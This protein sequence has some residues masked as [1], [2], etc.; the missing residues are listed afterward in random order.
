M[1]PNTQANAAGFNIMP[2]AVAR[3]A[4]LIR[5]QWLSVQFA[6]AFVLPLLF[7]TVVAGC[8]SG[9][10][11]NTDSST[12]TD[13]A[14]NSATEQNAQILG[15][16][17]ETDPQGG[18]T[19]AP[20][21]QL[22]DTAIGTVLTAGSDSR[23]LYT[24]AGDSAGV[25]NCSAACTVLWT[26]LAASPSQQAAL[27][28]LVASSAI[29][30]VE[31]GL[32]V[33]ERDDSQLQWTFNERPLYHYSGDGAA[34]EANGENFNGEWFVARPMPFE[35]FEREGF[36]GP[37]L[38]GSG[39]VNAGIDE[40]SVR[41]AGLDGLTLYTYTLDMAG[42]SVCNAGC[43]EDWPPLYADRGAVAAD[44]FTLITR[45]NGAA[46]WAYNNEPLYFYI[47]DNAPGDV[48]GDGAGAVWFVARP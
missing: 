7:L 44:G 31:R 30:S 2:A 35:V 16:N 48:T 41:R 13:P 15:A 25:S 17:T 3:T 34:G 8:S 24:F 40:P 37:L 18:S 21:V 45:N 36:N 6:K 29:G 10:D 46:Q 43:A 47:G 19:D 5:C 27:D 12:A 23:T 32:G 38:R 33:I 20:P 4:V 11:E 26:P 42:L 28:A 1:S 22:S 14:G 9:S 39:S